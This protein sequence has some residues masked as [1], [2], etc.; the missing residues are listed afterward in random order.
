MRISIEKALF[1]TGEKQDI[2]T[3]EKYVLGVL[4]DLKYFIIPSGL[5]YDFHPSFI[6]FFG[7]FMGNVHFSLKL[8]VLGMKLHLS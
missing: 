1:E 6:I 8:F 3:L 5:V 2:N 7:I 4:T